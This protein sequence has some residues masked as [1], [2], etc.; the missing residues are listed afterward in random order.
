M[1]F[2]GPISEQGIIKTVQADAF[3]DN[4]PTIGTSITP[5]SRLVATPDPTSADAD[6]DFGFSETWT[7][8]PV[9]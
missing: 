1:N 5:T 7:D 4:S 9:T 3:L 6:D 8:N 2:Y